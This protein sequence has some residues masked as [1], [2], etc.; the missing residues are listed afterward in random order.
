M[1]DQQQVSQHCDIRKIY[2]KDVSLETPNSPGLFKENKLELTSE[3]RL[4]TRATSLSQDLFEVLLTVTVSSKLGEYTAYLAEI[5]QAGIFSIRGF[6]DSQIGHML[7][8]FCPNVLFPFA[9]EEIASL[10]G[11][12]GF[13]HLLLNPVN[14]DGLYMQQ[15]RQQ[16]A[17]TG[18]VQATQ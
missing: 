2:L 6:E 3:V 16:T 7:H 10:I 8:A 12:S 13:P 9:R 5:Q 15:L 4:E 11:K 14:F 18:T 17:T 1:S